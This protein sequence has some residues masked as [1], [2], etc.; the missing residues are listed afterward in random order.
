VGIGLALGI[1]AVTVPVLKFVFS[2]LTIAIHEMGHTV[3]GWLFGYPSVPAFDFHYGGGVSY[4][5]DRS[6]PV[7]VGLYCFLAAAGWLH[8]RNR[9]TLGVLAGF[10]GVHA[11]VAYTDTHRVVILFMGHGFEILLAGVFLYRAMSG[12]GVLKGIE[13]PLYA[14]CGF[15]ILICDAAFAYGLATNRGRQ[16]LYEAAKGGGHWMDFSRIAE[17]HLHVELTSVA[18]FFGLCCLAVPL[19]SFLAF[20]YQ[21][22]VHAALERISRRA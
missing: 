7:L 12:S 15:F 4:H 11:L 9:L 18:T 10:V 22:H 16:V 13:R 2:Y 5:Q 3:F 6:I 19:L 1:A 20:R 8:R 21:N 14:F 17:Q